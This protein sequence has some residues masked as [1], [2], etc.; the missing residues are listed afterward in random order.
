VDETVHDIVKSILAPSNA[1]SHMVSMSA[2]ALEEILKMK[3]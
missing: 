3:L 1:K 2:D